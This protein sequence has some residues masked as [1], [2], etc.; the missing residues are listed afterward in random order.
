MDKSYIKTAI[1]QWKAGENYWFFDE[2]ELMEMFNLTDSDITRE[3][4]DECLNELY[5]I[6]EWEVEQ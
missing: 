2:S 3:L 6:Y 4:Y 1:L 5:E